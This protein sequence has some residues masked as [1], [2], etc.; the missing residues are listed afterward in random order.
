MLLNII[1]LGL[2]IICDI[3][4]LFLLLNLPLSMNLSL[5]NSILANKSFSVLSINGTLNWHLDTLSYN[6]LTFCNLTLG[7]TPLLPE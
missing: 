5:I 7:F 2:Q 1:G 4:F 6:R 3:K